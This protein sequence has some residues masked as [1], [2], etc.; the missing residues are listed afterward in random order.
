[1]S[2]LESEVEQQRHD[3]ANTDDNGSSD[4]I[5][6]ATAAPVDQ[7]L[8]PHVHAVT[9]S[10]SEDGN[11]SVHESEAAS[12]V[13]VDTSGIVKAKTERTKQHA[14]VLPLN[15]GTLVRKPDLGFHLDGSRVFDPEGWLFD[16]RREMALSTGS[17]VLGS[18]E[19]RQKIGEARAGRCWLS[20]STV[21]ACAS[22]IFIRLLNSLGVLFGHVG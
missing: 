8:S 7:A 13:V 10:A 5:E 6:V 20:G 9:P 18:A 4:G 16:A 21:V 3:Q 12:N 1:M 15:E 11:K 22:L 2:Y 14:D 19:G 17:R